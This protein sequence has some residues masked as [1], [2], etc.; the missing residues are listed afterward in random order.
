MASK[1]RAVRRP[2]ECLTDFPPH[3]LNNGK[4]E[5]MPTKQSKKLLNSGSAF[6]AMVE[7]IEFYLRR[8]TNPV[9]LHHTKPVCGEDGTDRCPNCADDKLCAALRLAREVK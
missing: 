6:D 9:Y 8:Q 7:A 1:K 2:W 5:T 3:R 4:V